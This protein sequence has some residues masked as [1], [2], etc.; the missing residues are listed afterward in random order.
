M[1]WYLWLIVA[2]VVIGVLYFIAKRLFGAQL[3]ILSWLSNPLG[4]L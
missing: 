2:A 1:E 4:N 3:S